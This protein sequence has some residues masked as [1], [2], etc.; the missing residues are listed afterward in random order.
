MTG[1]GIAAAG[2]GLL[3][4]AGITA[5]A[6]GTGVNDGDGAA[7]P[8]QRPATVPG[9][10][11]KAGAP[12]ARANGEFVL[13]GDRARRLLAVPGLGRFRVRCPAKKGLRG[14]FTSSSKVTLEVAIDRGNAPHK[15][16][17]VDPGKRLAL[18]ASRGYTTTQ[19]WQFAEVTEATAKVTV[20]FIASTPTSGGRDCVASAYALGPTQRAG[21]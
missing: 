17:F 20:V 12:A 18:P 13:A 4:A 2:S 1:R 7:S 9:S 8:T 15:S 6:L 21:G 19:R 10:A 11:A 14:A 5:L 3:C 16:A